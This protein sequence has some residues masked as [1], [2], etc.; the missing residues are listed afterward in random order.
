MGKMA[1]K[2]WRKNYLCL[3]GATLGLV[4]IFLPWQTSWITSGNPLLDNLFRDLG[5]HDS[6][7]L[8]IVTWRNSTNMIL[9]F[10]VWI[11][12]ISSIAVFLSPIASISQIIGLSM[13]GFYIATVPQSLFLGITMGISLSFGFFIALIGTILSIAS[14][15]RPI[16]QGYAKGFLFLGDRILTLNPLQRLYADFNLRINQIALIGAFIGIISLFVSWFVAT[17]ASTGLSAIDVLTT[18]NMN[19]ILVI[20]AMLFLIGTITSLITPTA[21]LIQL[22]G[23]I[24]FVADSTGFSIG[25]GVLLG[26]SS[27]IVLFISFFRTSLLHPMSSKRLISRL[28]T[29]G[30]KAEMKCPACGNVLK[31]VRDACPKCTQSSE[32]SIPHVP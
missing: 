24:I 5:N 25:L 2:D 27:A 32:S 16:G 8:E 20:A 26:F 31:H 21:L 3:I 18:R 10:G 9:V 1:F 15:I 13:V 23:L 17:S 28:L 14:L 22:T 7:L 4:S 29:F 11:F 6:S 30:L 19:D 12:T